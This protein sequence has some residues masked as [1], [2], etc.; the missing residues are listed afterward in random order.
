MSVLASVHVNQKCVKPRHSSAILLVD[1]NL[2]ILWRSVPL[3]LCVGC[4]Y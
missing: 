3:C 2:L 4:K 1:T